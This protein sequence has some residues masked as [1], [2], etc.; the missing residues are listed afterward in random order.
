MRLG[1]I[2]AG[3][4]GK[5]HVEA[6]LEAGVEVAWVVDRQLDSARELAGTCGAESSDSPEDLW[7]DSATNSVVIAVPNYLHLPLAN[8]ALEAGKDVLLEKP[9]AL[10]HKECLELSRVVETT[11]QILQVGYVHRY[12]AV[13]KVAKQ[14]ATGNKLGEIYHA[15][16]ML[17]LRRGIP[18]LGHWFTD[19]EYSG[20]GVLIDVGV[21]LIDLAMHLMGFPEVD[22]VLGQTFA[23]FGVRMGDYHFDEMWAGP[24]NLSGTFNVEDA[25]QALVRFN[26]GAVLDLHVAWAGNYSKQLPTSLMS[27]TGT[28]GGLS[29]EL[30]GDEVNHSLEQEGSLVDGRTPV[31]QND[32]FLEQMQ[33]FARSVET[34]SVRQADVKQGCEVQAIV[35]AIYSSSNH[36]QPVNA[37]CSI[38]ALE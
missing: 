36:R 10:T 16:A 8:T 27:F 25:A 19:R 29:F 21:H 9:M 31:E 28:Q 17:Y 3:T 22:Q 24:P 14:L 20:G 38:A 12:T 26:N 23:N 35:D 4:I 7:Q 37:D 34:R 30:F 11:G 5:K 18:G 32:F 33:D 1:I 15:Q 2:G 6:A 13:A